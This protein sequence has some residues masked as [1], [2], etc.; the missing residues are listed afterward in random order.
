MTRNNLKSFR[1]P[2]FLLMVAVS[3]SLV[4]PIAGNA[5][6]LL[7]TLNISSGAGNVLISTDHIN[8]G[9]GT[10]DVTPSTG[11]FSSLDGTTGTILN[12]DNPPYVAGVVFPTPDFMTFMLEPNITITLTELLAGT[13]SSTQCSLAPAPGQACTP[14]VPSM[15]PYNLNNTS[16]GGSTVS[17]I[18]FGTEV[19]SLTNTSTPI[20]GVFISPFSVPYQTLLATV[21]GGGTIETPFSA[22]FFA[23]EVPEP[24]TAAS[25]ALGG[26]GIA[27]LALFRRR[28]AES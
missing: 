15:A 13:D 16:T 18:V 14:N 2:S 23:T 26:F 6:L 22:T 7:G 5:S 17:F 12:I 27:G 21:N 24:G 28:R 3:V 19:D 11:S 1:S 4:F 8:F 9:S 20:I 25:L 10:F